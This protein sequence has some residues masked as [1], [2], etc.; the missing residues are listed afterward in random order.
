M[1]TIGKMALAAIALLLVL[2]LVPALIP[3]EA[4]SPGAQEWLKIA[5]TPSTVAPLQNRFHAQVGF[6]AAPG[7][8]MVEYGAGSGQRNP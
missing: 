2:A 1:K 6:L 7:A 3:D 8:D 5:R 4:Y